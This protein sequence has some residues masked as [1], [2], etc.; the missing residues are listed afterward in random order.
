MAFSAI[1][2][3]QALPATAVGQTASDHAELTDG[4]GEPIVIGTAHRIQST[5][6][7]ESKLISVRLPR[8]YADNPD[9]SYPVV[10]SVD[11]GPDQDF[12]LLSG[13]AAEAEFSTSFEPFILIGIRTDRR[14]AEL[15]P[16]LL[17]T[18][19]SALT[20]V[21]GE[22]MQPDGAPEFREF[23][24]RD[25]IPWATARYRTDRRVLTA[26]SL[27]GLFVVDTFF[28][29]PE[30]FDDYI[31]LTPALWWDDGRIA[32]EAA[33]KL[34][35]QA[36]SGKRIYITMGDE[37][38]GNRTGEWLSTLIAAFETSAAD[39]VKWAFADRSGGEEHRTMALTG[40]LDAFRTLY[41]RPGRV[42]N[43]IPMIYHGGTT[44]EYTVQARANIDAGACRH[45]IARPAEWA[46]KNAA[47][48]VYYGM[49]LLLKPG[50]RLT[51]T[52][53]AP[54]DYGLPISPD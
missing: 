30:L 10:F 28:E 34:G 36:R 29:R 26:A 13:I 44:P 23:L 1:L 42:G 8:G 16:L 25:V 18:K 11:G 52:N 32:D 31:A 3:W 49:C 20:A 19:A 51:A 7:G 24:A 46:E 43:P 2:A 50:P 6:Y 27:G 40:W 4:E 39:D 38:V 45:E 47:P 14:Y 33:A 5:V 54:G 22:R 15:T 12:E 53:F 17:R 41:L 48:D 35:A 21:F 37:G 9:K